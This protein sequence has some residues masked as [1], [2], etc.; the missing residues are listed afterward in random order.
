[1]YIF[2]YISLSVFEQKTNESCNY[3]QT[4]NRSVNKERNNYSAEGQGY[5][6]YG[7]QSSTYQ[8]NFHQNNNYQGR[9]NFN[10]E[11]DSQSSNYSFGGNNYSH[12]KS[13]PNQNQNDSFAIYFIYFLN[14]V[15]FRAKG[16]GQQWLSRK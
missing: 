16:S 1:M 4:N 9:S 15:S 14:I 11:R 5:N 12:T 10:N 6:K 2:K 7:Q 8:K 13:F 3:A